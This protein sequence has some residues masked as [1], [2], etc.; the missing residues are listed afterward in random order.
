MCFGSYKTVMYRATHGITWRAARL[1]ESW[2]PGSGGGFGREKTD[3]AGY[4]PAI[5]LC[6]VL[7]PPYRT[8]LLSVRHGKQAKKTTVFHINGTEQR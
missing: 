2:Y 5:E 7:N 8:A 6:S 4:I 1:G 3:S